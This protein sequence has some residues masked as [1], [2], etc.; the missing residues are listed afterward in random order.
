MPVQA[1]VEF[2]IESEWN[3]FAF[4]RNIFYI[5]T[6]WLLCGCVCVTM[7]VVVGLYTYIPQYL[8]YNNMVCIWED[9]KLS[10]QMEFR[11]CIWCHLMSLQLNEFWCICLWLKRTVKMCALFNTKPHDAS[12]SAEKHFGGS[13]QSLN[14][15]IISWS[16]LSG[17]KSK[18][19]RLAKYTMSITLK[20][21]ISVC[22]YH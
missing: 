22:T 5:F 11:I 10:Q 3:I 20:V 18:S 9:Y 21:D 14:E 1:T 7:S 19:A 4:H 13:V 2:R 8:L 15:H 16:H 17:G 6:R 12:N